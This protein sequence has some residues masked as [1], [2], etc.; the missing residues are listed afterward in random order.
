MYTEYP[1]LVIIA[2]LGVVFCLNVIATSYAL[3]RMH[4]WLKER[5]E[6]FGK[7]RNRGF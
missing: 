4:A 3:G 1:V 7:E 2:V 6:V 5:N